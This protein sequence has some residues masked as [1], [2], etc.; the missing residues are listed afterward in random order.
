MTQLYLVAR[1]SMETRTYNERLQLSGISWSGGSPSSAQYEYWTAGDRSDNNGQVRK[2]I[3]SGEQITYQYD[4][5]KRLIAA[6]STRPW[7]E[8]YSYDGFG[9]RT[10]AG[11]PITAATN[12]VSTYTYDSNG[13]VLAMPQM[14]LEYDV[15][16]RVT[17]ATQQTSGV[18][19][20]GYDPGGQRVMK[21]GVITLYGIDGNR[22]GMYTLGLI[23][24][25]DPVYAFRSVD[26]LGLNPPQYRWFAGRPLEQ[27][28]RV[29]SRSA[30]GRFTPLG[31]R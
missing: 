7:S 19:E 6:S 27:V 12:R 20:Y 11:V 10:G 22:I 14:T 8:T 1:G 29:G 30:G 18:D 2:T 17:R 15:D 25:T 28:D 5:L 23:G 13:N 3:A 21:N 4:S 24:S 16:N 9:N 26:Y 31:W